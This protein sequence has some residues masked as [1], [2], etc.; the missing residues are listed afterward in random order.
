[1]ENEE[2]LS[3]EVK[4]RE[5]E[6]LDKNIRKQITDVKEQLALFSEFHVGDTVQDRR[7]TQ[8]LVNRVIYHSRYSKY[9]G[10]LIKKDGTPGKKEREIHSEPITLVSR[11][12][13]H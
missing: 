4:L 11:G 7:G 1:M 13:E 2:K 6:K 9:Y 5:L 12:N 8:F 10:F 3:L